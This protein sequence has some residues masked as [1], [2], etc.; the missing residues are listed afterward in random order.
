MRVQHHLLELYAAAFDERQVLRKPQLQRDSLPVRFIGGEHN[1]LAN[2][3]VDL[4]DFVARRGFLNEAMNARHHLASMP[5]VTDDPI[6][7]LADLSPIRLVAGKPAQTRRR[8]ESDR[9]D[10]L[11]DLVA[12]RRRELSKRRD[13]VGMRE[14]ELHPACPL[15][16]VCARSGRAQTRCIELHSTSV[17]IVEY[18]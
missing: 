10:R 7:G 11:L 16:P 3:L 8:I 9:R 14:L 5:G 2:R 12:N 17:E 1:N 4:H 6:Q 15:P 13:A 18:S